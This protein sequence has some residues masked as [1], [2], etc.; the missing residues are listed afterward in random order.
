MNTRRTNMR[1]STARKRLLPLFAVLSVALGL[2]AAPVAGAAGGVPGRYIVTL[3]GGADV[4]AA[5][6]ALAGRYGGQV[7]QVYGRVLPGFSV[8]LGADAAGR[9]ARDSEVLAVT[10]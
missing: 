8:T 3:R 4:P 6:K 5:A 7:D 2:L 10:P 1:M 9:L